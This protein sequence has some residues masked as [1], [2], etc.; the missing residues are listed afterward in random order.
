[1]WQG[2]TLGYLIAA[3]I[4]HHLV[5]R[6]TWR[7]PFWTTAAGIRFLL[8]L[9]CCT[10]FFLKAMSS[11]LHDRQEQGNSTNLNP[12]TPPSSRYTS[13]STKSETSAH[14]P[15]NAGQLP[16]AVMLMT[17]F[18]TV[19]KISTPPIYKKATGSASPIPPSKRPPDTCGTISGAL[20]VSTSVAI[21]LPPLLSFSS[22]LSSHFGFHGLPQLHRQGGRRS[23][24]Y[25]DGAKHAR[26]TDALVS[27]FPDIRIYLVDANSTVVRRTL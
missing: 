17:G 22:E 19:S 16:P 7:A 1:M 3:V 24:P 27:V 18:P 26:P 2:Y 10:F 5:P 25:G 23:Q 21:S 13:S 6:N 14:T 8:S 4:Y 12:S 9:L 20:R 15:L 11:D